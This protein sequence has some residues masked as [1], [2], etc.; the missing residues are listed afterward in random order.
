MGIGGLNPPYQGPRAR[1]SGGM[2]TDN[3]GGSLGIL[4]VEPKGLSGKLG[5][6]SRR[7]LLKSSNNLIVHE[8]APPDIYA[9]S[10]PA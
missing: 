9:A 1:P 7:H 4:L 10:G 8:D 6:R 2:L 5:G 3:A